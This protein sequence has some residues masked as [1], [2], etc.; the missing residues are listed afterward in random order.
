MSY[1]A[2][3]IN[4]H[5]VSSVDPE[6]NAF[7]KMCDF[8]DVLQDKTLDERFKNQLMYTLLMQFLIDKG[9]KT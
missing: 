4:S 8:L 1:M 3:N 6:V 9:N 5:N 2:K 7:K